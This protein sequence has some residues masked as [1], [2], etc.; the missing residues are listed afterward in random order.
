MEIGG[1]GGIGA[2]GGYG[3]RLTI[4]GMFQTFKQ[5]YISSAA[6]PMRAA[7]DILSVQLQHENM[8][9]HQTV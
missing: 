2:I 4:H 3:E 1:I 5:G 8:I 6:L 9:G 7:I